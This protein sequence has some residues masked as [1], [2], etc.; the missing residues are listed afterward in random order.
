VGFTV[1]PKVHALVRARF[2]WHFP[3]LER[4][5]GVLDG[6]EGV[7]WGARGTPR[8][9]SPGAREPAVAGGRQRHRRRRNV[10]GVAATPSGRRG[11]LEQASLGFGGRIVVSENFFYLIEVPNMLAILE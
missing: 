9:S 7:P 1:E 3:H 2:L 8:V 5:Q 4:I 11:S 6:C 10:P